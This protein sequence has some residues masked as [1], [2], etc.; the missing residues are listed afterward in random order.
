MRRLWL[1]ASIVAIVGAASLLLGGIQQRGTSPNAIAIDNDDIAGTVTSAKGPEAGV[2]VIAETVGLPTRVRKIVVTN[3]QGRYLLPDLP[4][5]TY[6]IW[7]RGYGLVDSPKVQSAPGQQRPLTAVI[8]PNS[9]AAAHYY[10]ANYWYSLIEIPPEKDFP[11]TGPQGNGISPQMQTQHHWINQIKTNCNVCHQLGNPATREI[12]KALGKFASSVD[13]W[14]R[15]AQVGQD[16]QGMS[17]AV[18]A[19][20]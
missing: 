9:R 8:A 2:W 20:G 4:Q 16:G 10:P 1:T 19:L 6:D 11:G 15:R 3:D 17:N 18:S 12:P 7:V 13:A 5:A 14:D